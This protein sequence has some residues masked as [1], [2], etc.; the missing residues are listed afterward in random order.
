MR[1]F[2]LTL[3]CIV[4]A[5]TAF[6]PTILSTDVGK[7]WIISW[8]NGGIRGSLSIDELELSWSGPQKAQQLQLKDPK[9]REIAKVQS[10]STDTSLF[11][12]LFHRNTFGA[13]TVIR[14]TLALERDAEG[15]SNIE[16]SLSKRI[17]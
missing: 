5:F 7:G 4:L 17:I 15:I 1:W 16:R 10:L 11:T 8:I 14:P 3:A 12:L 13:T 2:W 6:L 9:G